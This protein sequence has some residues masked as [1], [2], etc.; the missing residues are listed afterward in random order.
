MRDFGLGE[1]GDT[2]DD[3]KG[4]I[5]SLQG[6]IELARGEQASLR[7]AGAT[8]DILAPFEG[9]ITQ[10][11]AQQ[12]VLGNQIASTSNLQ[13]QMD[14][15]QRQGEILEL[16]RALAFDPLRRQIDEVTNS[17]EEMPFDE[18][19]A[20]IK[21]EQ[22][23]V[24]SLTAQWDQ[25]NAAMKEQ[26]A[27]VEGAI[28][29]RDRIQETYDA[30]KLSLDELGE[31]Y[32]SIE[33]RIRSMKSELEGMA[34]AASA[35]KE[36]LDELST[37]ESNFTDAGLGDYEIPGGGFTVP[38][39]GG[40]LEI[41]DLTKD[42]Q[43]E[44]DRAF[45]E[46]DILAPLKKLFEKGK[47]WVEDN[48]AEIG[49][50]IIGTI[51]FGMLGGPLWAAL[52]ILLVI[53]KDEAFRWVKDNFLSV[54]IGIITAI[55]FGIVTWGGGGAMLLGLALGAVLGKLLDFAANFARDHFGETGAMI[56]ETIGEGIIN[57]PG[58]ML[59][60]IVEVLV[61]LI[62]R[63]WNWIH[64]RFPDV[65]TKIIE[66]IIGGL[67]GK[68]GELAMA[69]DDIL[70][71]PIERAIAWGVNKGITALNWLIDQIN[72]LPGVDIGH[73]GY[74]GGGGGDSTGS[75]NRALM[76]GQDPYV[77][78]MASGGVVPGVNLA[79][80]G[81]FITKGARAIVGEGSKT[82]PEFVIPTDPRFRGRAQGLYEQLG[83]K[84]YAEGGIIN[85]ITDFAKSRSQDA[86]SAVFG[87]IHEGMAKLISA[88]GHPLIE[89]P[90][91]H[92]NN[93]LF[94]WLRGVQ[95]DAAPSAGMGGGMGGGSVGNG[96]QAITDY[97][98]SV[99]MDY[100][101]TSTVR[102]GAMT[103]DGNLSNHAL[104]KAVDLVGDMP[105]IF[106]ILKNIGQSL[107]ELFFDPAGHS[108]KNGQIVDWIAG[109]HD[110]HVH[111]ATFAKG[112]IMRAANGALIRATAG[113]SLIRAGEGG[114]D[115][116]VV[117]LPRNMRA[118]GLGL[119]N[120]RSEIHFHGDLSFPNITSADDAEE[121][122]HNLETLAAS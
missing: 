4:K 101:V 12:R 116:A 57:G 21:A 20:K 98:D 105:A 39:E 64:E 51:A 58:P 121:F 15:L 111:A 32:D 115:E 99:G 2:V 59:F 1:A 75:A 71:N 106:N 117:P 61:R 29:A 30:E 54:G 5:S 56:V 27:V 86:R 6:D 43:A 94:D 36:K 73:I 69:L 60:A 37:V 77:G 63:A 81:P 96:W 26:E 79:R 78:E 110:D 100:T 46:V 85:K 47:K 112:G 87:P 108:I 28:A 7:Q 31:A 91:H 67:F 109:G 33:E 13:K 8:R 11:E 82:H 92:A 48:F 10:M 14:D 9:Q 18:L 23:N 90:L 113:G 119:G 49:V 68:A 22:A 53:F 3:L 80:T 120:A 107:S 93:A 52:F 88:I 16:E 25:A 24:A 40:L 118:D 102:P 45:G 76:S 114:Q 55:I 62:D 89:P 17:M 84:L 104:G 66:L 34:S 122:I 38:G 41:E 70:G 95:Q 72:R 35:A 83:T 44:L 50:A 97:L 103:A 42:W 74:V 65:G 19:L